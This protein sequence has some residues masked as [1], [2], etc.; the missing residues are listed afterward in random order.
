MTLTPIRGDYGAENIFENHDIE[1]L[2][3][4]KKVMPSITGKAYKYGIRLH[5]WIPGTQEE[6]CHP[7]IQSEAYANLSANV[8]TSPNEDYKK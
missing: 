5:N 2:E 3:Y 4:I 7:Q 6:G 8:T 1:A